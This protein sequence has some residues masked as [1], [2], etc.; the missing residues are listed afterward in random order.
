MRINCFLFRSILGIL[1]LMSFFVSPLWAGCSLKGAVSAAAEKIG[2]AVISDSGKYPDLPLM[3]VTGVR[4]VSGESNAFT[5]NIQEGLTRELCNRGFR[6]CERSRIDEVLQENAL[7]LKGAFEG[8]SLEMGK[9][10][11]ARVVVT[12][13]VKAEDTVFDLSIRA[14]DC[15]SGVILPYSSFGGKISADR[16]NKRLFEQKGGL[17]LSVFPLSV[18]GSVHVD[19]RETLF[20]GEGNNV[21][22]L[23]LDKGTHRLRVSADGYPDQ[24]REVEITPMEQT[25]LNIRMRHPLKVSIWQEDLETGGVIGHQGSVYSG[26]YYRFCVKANHD[27][28]VYLFNKGTS[29]RFFAL[30]LPDNQVRA[31][32]VTRLPEAGGFKLDAHKGIEK[33]YLL[34]SLTPLNDIEKLARELQARA[35]YLTAPGIVRVLEEK[36]RTA[37]VKDY[38][39]SE[40]S[41]VVFENASLDPRGPVAGALT[42]HH[43]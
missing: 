12:G 15:Q 35:P 2:D 17:V 32:T 6:L 10:L 29:G 26:R 28:Y 38:C 9:L 42:Y 27:C 30:G 41:P 34:A 3:A 1:F 33:I 20:G 25:I 31:E 16:N 11:N 43:E 19:G 37:F 7:S 40:N 39:R 13:T 5:A 24:E 21:V 23:D 18:S 4:T 36:R 8:T 14:V 22:T